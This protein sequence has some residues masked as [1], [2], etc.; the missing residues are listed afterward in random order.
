ML[1]IA[2]RVDACAE[3]EHHSRGARSGGAAV[4]G[5]ARH[6]GGAC[7]AARSAV[8]RIGREVGAR[9]AA[10]KL[11]RGTH[12]R[13]TRAALTDVALRA[14][15]RARPAIG[16]VGE[17]VDACSS[18]ARLA[19]R[20]WRYAC[21]AHAQFTRRASVTAAAAMGRVARD[22]DADAVARE[23]SARARSV[24]HA[25]ACSTDLTDRA[26]MPARTAVRHARV[27]CDAAVRT[28]SGPAVAAR[29][30]GEGV[31][32]CDRIVPC[33]GG[34]YAIPAGREADG[35][36]HRGDGEDIARAFRV[37][38]HCGEC[39]MRGPAVGIACAGDQLRGHRMRNESP[40]RHRSGAA[41]R[42]S[43][44]RLLLPGART[45]RKRSAF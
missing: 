3:A 2:L 25:C 20:A 31:V 33:I 44:A 23:S 32:A 36:E 6:A 29:R 34:R 17:Y 22:V 35:D 18:A 13:S 43:N 8:H 37:P 12:G 27:E 15:V 41:R 30:V 26:G 45:R 28:R 4:P 7:L 10:E 42:A 11:A 38:N 14:C 19:G 40:P 39:G 9:G 21:R 24:P 16:S 5:I 1:R